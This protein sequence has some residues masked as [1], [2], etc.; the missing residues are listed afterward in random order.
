MT[1][2]EVIRALENCPRH[3]NCMGCPFEKTGCDLGELCAE[4]SVHIM[5]QQAEIERLQEDKNTY[6]RVLKKTLAEIR[7]EAIKDFSKRLR[8]KACLLHFAE[9]PYRAV[10]VLALCDITAVEKELTEGKPAE[11]PKDYSYGY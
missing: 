9:H 2:N 11:L 4:A 1:E 7:A 6:E 10:R 8:E 5:R 3:D